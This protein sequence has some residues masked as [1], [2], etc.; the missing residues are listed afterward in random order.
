MDDTSDGSKS[1]RQG[2]IRRFKETAEKARLFQSMAEK[3]LRGESLTS[4]EYW[5]IL[6][7]GR[8]AEHHFLI[9][10]SL[11]NKDYAL[12]TPDPIAK[13]AD[14]AGGGITPFLMA[15][16][17]KP[18]EWDHIVPFFG[19]HQIVKGPVYS[20]YEFHSDR[21]LNDQDWRGMAASQA[22]P[23]WIRPFFADKNLSCP[24]HTQY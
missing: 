19:R 22:R 2:V 12:S 7:V 1:L 13:I 18:V 9:F 21:L 8:V 14:V 10:K 20:Y 5:E 17:G 6:F 16:V 4:K 24:A 3:Q 11:A 23:A 15:A